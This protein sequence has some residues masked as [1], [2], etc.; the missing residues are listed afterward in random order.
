MLVVDIGA[1]D[2]AVKHLEY[3]FSVVLTEMNQEGDV[4]E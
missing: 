4:A 1:G 3:T 2:V